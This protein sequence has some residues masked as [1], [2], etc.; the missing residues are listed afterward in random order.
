MDFLEGLPGPAVLLGGGARG[1]ALRLEPRALGWGGRG[2]ACL[3][4]GPW[5]GS[6]MMMEEA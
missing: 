6:R 5:E 2:K 4:T 1:L 3:R